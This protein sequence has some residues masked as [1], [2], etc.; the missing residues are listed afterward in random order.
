MIISIIRIKYK[1]NDN[2]DNE[3]YLFDHNIQI[4]IKHA[5]LG[6]GAAKFIGFI[7]EI[8]IYFKSD[9]LLFPPVYHKRPPR[10]P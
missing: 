10:G 7:D 4:Y 2:F 6:E 8:S 9:M 3:K 1:D 5:V